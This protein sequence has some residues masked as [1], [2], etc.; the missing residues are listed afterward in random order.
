MHHLLALE[1]S[2]DETAASVIAF[3]KETFANGIP[4]SIRILAQNVHS[5]I[6][7]HQ[8]THGVVPEVAARHHVPV[9]LPLVEGVLRRSRKTFHEIDALAVTSG[10][11]LITSLM[12]GV[13]TA[14]TLALVFKKPLI[15]VNHIEAHIAGTFSVAGE[16]LRFPALALVVSGGH[17]E[18]LHM[19]R[20]G[21]Y[22]FVGKTRDDAVGEAFDK[23]AKILG[24]GYPGGPAIAK[25]AQSANVHTASTLRFPRPMIEDVS[26]D[27]SFSGLKTAVRYHVQQFPPRDLGECAGICAAFQEAVVDLLLTKTLRAVQKTKSQS[28]LLVGGVAAN[29]MLRNAL[30]KHAR[31]LGVPFFVPPVNLCTDNATMVALAAM[32]HFFAHDFIDPLVLTARA[33][34]E[35]AS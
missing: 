7:V 11:G 3:S 12:V 13:E 8:A 33:D 14:K 5:Q 17:T 21:E 18:L 9:I 6:S 35:L 16:Q 31:K 26:F 27:M 30:R 1:T 22:T 4:R 15:A 2:C 19:P 24:L 34:W 10:P 25:C 29:Q 32:Q 23:V 20:I 28:I